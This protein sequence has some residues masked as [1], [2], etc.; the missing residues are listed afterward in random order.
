MLWSF[1]SLGGGSNRP[2]NIHDPKCTG[3]ESRLIDCEHEVYTYFYCNDEE[4]VGIVC[5]GKA[6]KLYNFKIL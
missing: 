4:N 2:I 1:C 6:L 5:D 3:N